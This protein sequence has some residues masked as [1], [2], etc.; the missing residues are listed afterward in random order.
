M[1][2]GVDIDTWKLTLCAVS[3]SMV[4]WE[5]ATLR[6]RGES[7]LDAILGTQHAVPVAVTRLG[8]ASA[9]T[10]PTEY[11]VER[12]RGQHR[13]ADFDLGAIYGAT[14]VALGRR[15][16]DAHVASMDVP[17]WKRAVT[18]AV[19]IKTAR[20]RPGNANVPKVVANEACRTLLR[21]RGLDPSRLSPDELDAFGIAYAASA[22]VVPA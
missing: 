7:L 12:G 18:A 14:C 2:V 19:G 21:E 13:K 15:T 5:T 1:I 20:G 17:D 6:R 4:A 11:H 10:D 9:E 8:I 22:V 16:P 3:E